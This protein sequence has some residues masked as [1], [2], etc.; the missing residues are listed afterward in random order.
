MRVEAKIERFRLAQPFTIA[1]GSR[2]EAVVLKVELHDGM[3]CGHGEGLPY[4]HYGETPDGV[5]SQIQT[6]KDTIEQGIDRIA[7]KD[8]MPAG[9]A[10]NAIDAALWS[11]EAKQTGISVANRLGVAPL[12]DLKTMLTISLGTPSEMATAAR[13]VGDA[14][15]LKIKLG[16]GLDDVERINAVREASP[17]SMIVVDANEGWRAEDLPTLFSALA[18]ADVAMIEQPLPASNDDALSAM[19]RPIPVYA[20]E[21]VRNDPD[22]TS[23]RD[24][25]DGIN[26]KLDKTG[27][28]SSALEQVKVARDYDLGVM[29]GCMVA[30]S[31]SM[32][33]AHILAQKADYVDLDAPFLLAE[34]R[35]NAMVVKN[36]WISPPDPRLWGG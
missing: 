4:A 8:R 21:S 7:L 17:A 34:D 35:K 2:T 33:P 24:R 16:N 26:I 30:T 3:L 28:L 15:V 12:Q 36:G 31:L 9:A 10:R 5:L 32:A 14:P 18:D 6:V 25:Y 13:K 11:L 27:G 19:D 22:W 20:D 1:R 29:I 23:L